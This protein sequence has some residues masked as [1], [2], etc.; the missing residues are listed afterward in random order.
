MA[1]RDDTRSAVIRM[2]T[3]VL[4]GFVIRI[5]DSDEIMRHEDRNQMDIL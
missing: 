1:Y 3:A 4:N 2:V 5:R